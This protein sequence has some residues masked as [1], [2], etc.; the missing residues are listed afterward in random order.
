MLLDFTTSNLSTQGETN[1]GITTDTL[2]Q[3]AHIG[4]ESL[5]TIRQR[6]EHEATPSS[7]ELLEIV[8]SALKKIESTKV[9][10]QY[11]TRA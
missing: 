1:M 3:I 8:N 6:L 4:Q 9:V 5:Y 11:Y 2:E 7:K 10:G